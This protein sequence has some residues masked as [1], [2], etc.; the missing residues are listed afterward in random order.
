MVASAVGTLGRSY[1]VWDGVGF[2]VF[3]IPYIYVYF[4]FKVL[5]TT[6]NNCCI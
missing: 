2:H 5:F 1:M 6:F 3:V 4:S